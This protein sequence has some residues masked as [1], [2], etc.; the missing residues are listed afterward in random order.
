MVEVVTTRSDLNYRSSTGKMSETGHTKASSK[1]YPEGVPDASERHQHEQEAGE[2]D[3]EVTVEMQKHMTMLLKVVERSR[4]RTVGAKREARRTGDDKGV[5]L[6]KLF[7]ADDMEAY[8]TSFEQMMT[9]FEVQKDWW[10]FKVA[11]HLTG[12]A[13]HAYATMVVEDACEY[14]LMLGNGTI[15]MRRRTTLISGR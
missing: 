1:R 5:T 2:G 6:T 14:E 10:V 8:L 15:S 7:K 4:E 13:Q 9:A 3:G 11:S 12:M